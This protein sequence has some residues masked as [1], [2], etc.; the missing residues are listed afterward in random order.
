MWVTIFVSDPLKFK[1]NNIKSTIHLVIVLRGPFWISWVAPRRISTSNFIQLPCH[2][3]TYS[4]DVGIAVF[5]GI[6]N[7]FKMEIG[8]ILPM[9]P[10]PCYLLSNFSNSDKKPIID[11]CDAENS[12]DY[13]TFF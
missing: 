13:L 10:V 6:N 3:I 4:D 2:A 8:G 5:F 1:F 9:L 7:L 12:K 11:L